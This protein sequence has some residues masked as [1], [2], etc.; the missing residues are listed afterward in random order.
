VTSLGQIIVGAGIYANCKLPEAADR[1]LHVIPGM[2]ENNQGH[3]KT[4]DRRGWL[5][6]QTAD[7]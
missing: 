1:Q 7:G 5:H 2:T 3:N 6:K 4:A